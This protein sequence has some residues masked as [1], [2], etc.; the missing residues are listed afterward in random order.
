METQC[1]TVTW[2]SHSIPYQLIFSERKTIGISVY[3]DLSVVVKA[4]LGAESDKI[5][6]YLRKRGAW[7]VK[8]QREF[9]KYLPKLP[10]RRY[11]GGETHRYLGRQYRLK[12]EQGE[13]ESILLTRGYYR[14]TTKSLTNSEKIKE[15]L[16]DWYRKKAEEIFYD[17][18]VFCHQKMIRENLP[19]PEIV[20]RLMK[21]RWGSLSIKGKMTLNLFLIKA[22]K[23][24]IDY[25]VFHEL[26]HLKIK[27]H[28]P[29]FWRLL[30]KYLPDYD[31]R[32]KKI[33][34]FFE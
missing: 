3:P 7:I 14:I 24:C 10:P 34:Q 28:G 20:I 16:F 32:R 33:G 31:E 8:S 30:E 23:E 17:R 18:V 27:H 11:I 6:H 2:G 15:L 13:S 19:F 12:V 25:V 26:C 21:K 29:K 22:P 9:E 4:P 5:Q 1:G